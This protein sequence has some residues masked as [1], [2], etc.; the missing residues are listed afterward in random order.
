MNK[1]GTSWGLLSIVCRQVLGSEVW[2]TGF[3]VIDI[4]CLNQGYGGS[5]PG[6]LWRVRGLTEARI[7]SNGTTY[8]VGQEEDQ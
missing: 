4:D 5:H 7:L 2:C 8:P 1:W 3:Q 6:T